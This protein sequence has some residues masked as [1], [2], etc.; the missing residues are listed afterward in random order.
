VNQNKCPLESC[1]KDDGGKMEPLK[2][3][4]GEIIKNIWQ[5]SVCPLQISDDDET[6]NVPS[7]EEFSELVNNKMI[8]QSVSKQKP[9]IP[10]GYVP[11]H[12]K[13]GSKSGKSRKKKPKPDL[14]GRYRDI[15]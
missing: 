9:Y 15:K 2:D 5:C 3:S 6:P 11:G 12:K 1:P 8:I 7:K 4:K 14:S 13:G 10:F